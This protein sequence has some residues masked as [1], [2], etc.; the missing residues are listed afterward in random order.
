MIG[1]DMCPE[2]HTG[3]VSK[4]STEE[5]SHSEPLECL[6]QRFLLF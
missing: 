3:I 5:H 2:A 4:T 6:F 1:G